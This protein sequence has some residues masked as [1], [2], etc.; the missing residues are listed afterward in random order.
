MVL[1]G[2]DGTK[3]MVSRVLLFSFA[4]TFLIILHANNP[5]FAQTAA[6]P[7]FQALYNQVEQMYFAPKGTSVQQM[8]NQH[9]PIEV[10]RVFGHALRQQMLYIRN[11]PSIEQPYLSL[12]EETRA[13]LTQMTHRPNYW[14]FAQRAINGDYDNDIWN[15][16][17]IQTGSAPSVLIGQAGP[18]MGG[19]TGNMPFQQ[20][21]LVD[22]NQVDLLGNRPSNNF[23]QAKAEFNQ[24]VDFWNTGTRIWNTGDHETAYGYYNMAGQ[25]FHRACELGLVDGCRPDGQPGE[26]M[27]RWE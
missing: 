7:A 22:P 16:Y 18:P 8:I 13:Y 20:E 26:T 4:L 19:N 11:N 2:R 12:A 24:G 17:R 23:E 15:A 1:W 27:M 5:A 9:P 21:P 25:K 6:S 3:E 14:S 10:F